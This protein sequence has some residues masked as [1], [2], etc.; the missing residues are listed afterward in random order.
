LAKASN[1]QLNPYVDTPHKQVE[2]AFK[3]VRT[4]LLFTIAAL[5]KKSILVTSAESGAG[6]ST[7]VANIAL[8][9]S[10]TG[11]RVV[12]VDADM[13]KATQHR[14]FGVSN[15]NGF[16][17]MLITQENSDPVPVVLEN[18]AENLYLFPSGPIPPNP[19]ELLG[20]DRVARFLSTMLDSYDYV[21]VDAPPINLVA[22]SLVLTEVVGG[23]LLVVRQ[24]QTQ[25]E[26]ITRM[27]QV[28][29][30]RNAKIVGAVVTDVNR[31]NKVARKHR[32]SS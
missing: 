2:E 27:I 12:I 1:K 11:S 15:E 8:A 30:E 14:I 31:K 4:N 20:T 5:K 13:R 29:G 28:L 23:T 9:L 10:K 25:Y 26:E 24:K 22:D 17:Q 21:L 32:Y 6:K 18:V 19:A 16:S 3:I 7:V